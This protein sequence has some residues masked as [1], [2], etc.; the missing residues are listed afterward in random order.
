M[1]TKYIIALDKIRILV[2]F[3]RFWELFIPLKWSSR[4]LDSLSMSRVNFI[5]VTTIR[6]KLVPKISHLSMWYR[7]LGKHLFSSCIILQINSNKTQL[8]EFLKHA[9]S[10]RCRMQVDR[11]RE[12][13]NLRNVISVNLQQQ[14]QHKK[15]V[16]RG[17]KLLQQ[18]PTAFSAS[19]TQVGGERDFDK[20]VRFFYSFLLLSHFNKSI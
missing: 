15:K 3:S 9:E 6:F 12:E 14:K 4:P 7:L 1:I 2:S 13:E 19:H 18:Q 8:T 5:L 16:G 10:S 20:E 17:T 11:Q